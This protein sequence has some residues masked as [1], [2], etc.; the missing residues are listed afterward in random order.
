MAPITSVWPFSQWGIDIVGSL[1]I[2]PGGVRFLV[3]A[4][5]YFK[6]FGVP[7]II[8][9][10]NRKQFAEGVFPVFCQRLGIYQSFTSVYYPQVNGQVEVTNRDIVKG[11]E[12]RLRK[13]HQG[14]VDELPQIL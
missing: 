7:Q 9:S 4:I 13:N 10:D 2:A 8:I 5:D 3:V 11:M 12:R 6:K 1:L 14:W